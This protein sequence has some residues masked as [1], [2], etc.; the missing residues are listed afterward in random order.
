MLL[1]SDFLLRCIIGDILFSFDLELL[2]IG[3]KQFNLIELLYNRMIRMHLRLWICVSHVV[4]EFSQT[5]WKQIDYL[6]GR[7]KL[8]DVVGQYLLGC[9]YLRGDGVGIDQNRGLRLLRPPFEKRA[10]V[11]ESREV[12]NSQSRGILQCKKEQCVDL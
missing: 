7:P 11:W 8:G 12:L 6:I 3:L 10:L 1:L 5:L 2:N 4:E 9:C